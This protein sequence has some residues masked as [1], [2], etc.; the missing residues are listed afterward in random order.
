MEQGTID[1][2]LEGPAR[3]RCAV[4]SQ[5]LSAKPD[6]AAALRDEAIEQL[7]RRLNYQRLDIRALGTGKVTWAETGNAYWDLFS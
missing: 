6:P 1:W 5:L 2:L 4:E 3:L 7:L